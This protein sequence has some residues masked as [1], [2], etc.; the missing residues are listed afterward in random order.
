MQE[1]LGSILMPLTSSLS[2]SSRLSRF[3]SADMHRLASPAAVIKIL[4]WKEMGVVE[5]QA[6]AATI[7]YLKTVQ[8]KNTL[9]W[10]LFCSILH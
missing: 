2:H 1:D 6:Q 10:H 9:L 5:P 7:N 8:I 3:M 4:I